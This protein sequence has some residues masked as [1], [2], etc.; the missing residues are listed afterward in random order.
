MI[1]TTRLSWR[2]ASAP[3]QFC[4]KT[5]T[6]PQSIKWSQELFTA[7]SSFCTCFCA[8]QWWRKSNNSWSPLGSILR[9]KIN[10]PTSIKCL[11]TLMITSIGLILIR[12]IS[13]M[14]RWS[15]ST[16][17]IVCPESGLHHFTPF[18]RTLRTIS[19]ELSPPDYSVVEWLVCHAVSLILLWLT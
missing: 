7:C 10:V 19:V 16:S 6:W 2:R 15:E 1:T 4:G 9:T 3:T 12:N 8:M 18:G 11:Q 14:L 17:A 13:Q 5:T